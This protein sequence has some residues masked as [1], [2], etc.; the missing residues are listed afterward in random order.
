MPF[1]TCA[2]KPGPTKLGE[3]LA[4]YKRQQETNLPDITFYCDNHSAIYSLVME[5]DFWREKALNP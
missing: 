4:E 2:G 5:R 1:H 3:E